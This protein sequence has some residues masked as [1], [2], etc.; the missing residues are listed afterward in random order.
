MKCTIQIGESTGAE[1]RGLSRWTVATNQAWWWHM[2]LNGCEIDGDNSSYRSKAAAIKNAK[3]WAGRLGLT[4]ESVY[5]YGT[6][7]D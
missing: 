7:P 1:N 4:V 5:E 2:D 6:V 3:L